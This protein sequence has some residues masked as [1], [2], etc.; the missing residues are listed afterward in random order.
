MS[1]WPDGSLW[2]GED[3]GSNP[4]LQT[5]YVVY[6]GVAIAQVVECEIV[7]LVVWVQAPLVT[8]NVI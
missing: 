7:N 6:L 4:T 5:N 3:V 2:K 1:A 8:T